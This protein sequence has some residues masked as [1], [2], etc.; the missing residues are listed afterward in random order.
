MDYLKEAQAAEVLQVSLS[1]LQKWRMMNK[2]PR[3]YRLGG[4]MIR[5]LEDDLRVYLEGG[6]NET[7]ET[8]D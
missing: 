2:G 1:T 5:Y 8:S 3:Y 4:R 6:V 7:V